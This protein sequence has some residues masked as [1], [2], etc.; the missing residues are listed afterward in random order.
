M[1]PVCLCN[2]HQTHKLKQKKHL[3]KQTQANGGAYRVVASTPNE[4]VMPKIKRNVT[5]LVTKPERFD[6]LV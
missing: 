1:I 4:V 5:S 6:K 2:P 3:G